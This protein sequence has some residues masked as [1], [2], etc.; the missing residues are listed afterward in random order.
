MLKNKSLIFFQGIILILT[1][2]TS[3]QNYAL[4]I[5]TYP[6]S[7]FYELL[8][9][10]RKLK[11][12]NY[13]SFYT[14]QGV[15]GKNL[16]LYAVLLTDPERAAEFSKRYPEF[17]KYEDVLLQE[18]EIYLTEYK[19]E[20]EIITTPNAIWK[21]VKGNIAEIYR[22][23]L[24]DNYY[25]RDHDFTCVNVSRDGKSIVF[26]HDNSIIE[27]NPESS[28]KKVL[29]KGRFWNSQPQWSY[30]GKYIAYYD[31]K[32]WEAYTDLWV[33]T[34][35]SSFDRSLTNN[36]RERTQYGVHFF[37]WHPEKNLIF[38]IE[39]YAPGTISDGGTLYITDLKG[40]RKILAKDNPNEKMLMVRNFTIENDEIVY[41]INKW[42]GQLLKRLVTFSFRIPIEN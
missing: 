28:E 7:H 38:Y 14:K 25:P 19:N 4:W 10:Q 15:K 26:F 12:D 16:G 36:L 34:P 42:D 39:G 1:S 5:K 30:D 27:I 37:K 9:C 32:E 6:E 33:M 41:K 29:K 23:K 8:D 2:L 40:N 21:S 31:N 18:P 17:K 22:F 24:G 3:A 20:Y 35:D 13:I 11:N